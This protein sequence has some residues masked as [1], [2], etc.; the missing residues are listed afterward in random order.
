MATEST[1]G[2]YVLGLDL[3]V[4]SIGW[5]LVGLDD[6]TR[7]KR[8][9]RAG[10]HLFEAGIDGGKQDPETALATGKEKSRATPRRQ[11]RQQRRQIWR[12]AY[13]K[14]RLLK[15]L[16][17]YGFLPKPDRRF[18]DPADIDSYLKTVDAELRQEWEE[19]AGAD[20]RLRQLL[21]Y[22]L[23]AEALDHRLEAHE[24]G[25]AV[26]HLAQRR[27]FLSNRKTDQDA[28]GAD[29]EDTGKVKK[30]ISELEQMMHEAGAETLGQFFASLDPIDPASRRIRGR[31]TGRSMYENEFDRIWEAQASDHPD[32]MTTEARQSIRE[33]IFQQRPLKS[34]RHLIGRCSLIPEKRRAPLADRLFQRFRM[35]QK[36]NDLEVLLPDTGEVRALNDAEQEK[37]FAVLCA[38]D[39]TF[40][41]L[42]R[43]LKGDLPKNARFNFE[44]GGEKKLPGLRTDEKLRAVFGERWEEMD[45]RARD[46]AV[47]DCLS[48]ERADAME[49]RGR[50]HW[51]LSAE[52]ARAFARAKLEEGYAAYSRAALRELLPRLEKGVRLQTARHELFPD[53]F[54]ATEPVDMLPSLEEAF[55]EPVSPAVA[56]ALSEMRSVVN[57]IIRRYGKPEHIR[58]ELARELKKG[59]KRRESISKQIA[60]RRKLREDAAERLLAQYPHRAV[61]AIDKLKVRLADEC[62]WQCPY[63]GRCF[64]WD[65]LFGPHPTIDIEHIW[66]FSR[67]LDNSFINKTL[68]CVRENHDV[69]RNRMPAEAYSGERFDQILQR[70]AKF[71]GDG[72]RPKLERFRASAMP[73]DFTNRHLSESQYVSRKAAEY[74]ARLYG[75][76]SD[77]EHT[78]RVHVTSGGLTAWLRQEWGMHAILSDRDVTDRSDHRHHALDAI[79]VALTTQSTVKKLEQAAAAA[80]DAGSNRLFAEIESPFD[81]E[82]ARRAIGAIVVSHRQSRKARGKFHKDTIYSRPLPAAAGKRRHRI[83]KELH[84][85]NDKEIGEIVDPR[86]RQAVR[87]AY[88]ERK[89][90]GAKNPAQAFSEAEHH[91]RL[92]NGDRIRRVRIFTSAQPENVG[93]PG[94]LR[95]VDLQSNHHTVIMARLNRDGTEKTWIDEPVSMRTVLERRRQGIPIVCREVP[96]G[97]RF[98]STLAGNEY[99]EMD[100]P[101][102]NGRTVY[103]IL[104]VSEGFIEIREHW[105]GRTRKELKESG[106]KRE[107]T[108]GSALFKRNARKVYVNHLGEVHDA[109]G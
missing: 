32:L 11:A 44:E 28:A 46:A 6:G 23:R 83:R 82:D 2:S 107:I 8:I 58:I 48:Y 19:K 81:M 104:N 109:G 17:R 61:A 62:G 26:Y 66:P 96:D 4:A 91:P 79:V 95:R 77:E 60:G 105:D 38:G 65:D 51:R 98:K 74:V 64:G 102:G 78:R 56:R 42:R 106:A 34:Q 45:E 25:R 85:L 31:W 3:G 9:I 59:R 39:A 13:R 16:I 101:D 55:A 57:A 68:C 87:K 14:R 73:P 33:A 21:P 36:V 18:S 41:A 86:I 63:T 75:G 84:K 52:S 1:T 67:S 93:K 40:P 99:V 27:G 43:A 90:E 71:K 89:A 108:R 76:L 53:S 103:R 22:R 10:V 29:E 35:I 97:Y 69:K 24:V 50:E 94:R 5:G 70:V 15:R 47:Q 49:R 20:H 80:D 12:R 30:G 88:D 37:V 92:P 54:V 100:R 7:P 72:A